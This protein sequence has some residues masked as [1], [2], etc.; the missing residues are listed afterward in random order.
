MA[1]PVRFDRPR[2]RLAELAARGGES[3]ADLSQMVRRHDGYLSRFVRDGVPAALPG[4]VKRLLGAYYRTDPR[5]FGL[6]E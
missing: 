4:E 2:E 3:F 1:A 6:S 5:E